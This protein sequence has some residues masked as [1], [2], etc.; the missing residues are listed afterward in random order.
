[1]FCEKT[2]PALKFNYNKQTIMQE[3]LQYYKL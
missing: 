2:L 3:K 1:M